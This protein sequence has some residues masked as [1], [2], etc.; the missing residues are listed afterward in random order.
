MI[1]RSAAACYKGELPNDL[2][3]ASPL[4]VLHQPYPNT[5]FPGKQK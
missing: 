1:L 5:L 2:G 4:A 3:S